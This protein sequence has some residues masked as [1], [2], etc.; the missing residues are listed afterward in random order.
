MEKIVYTVVYDTE[1]FCDGF[2][3]SSYNDA[4][5]SA[6]NILMEWIYEGADITWRPMDGTVPTQEQIDDWNY[7][8]ENNECRIYKHAAGTECQDHDIVWYMDQEDV[9]PIGWKEV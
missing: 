8:I 9:E 2:D 3:C 6:L 4:V 1:H 7:F 5:G